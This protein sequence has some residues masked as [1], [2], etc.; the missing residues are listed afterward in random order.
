MQKMTIQIHTPFIRLDALLKLASIAETGGHAKVI[1]QGGM[2]RLNG[3]IC[4]QR[5]KKI[6]PG[7][8]ITTDDGRNITVSAEACD[9]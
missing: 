2:I 1:I 4:T 9:I 6:I 7:D 8:H 3:E 5:G